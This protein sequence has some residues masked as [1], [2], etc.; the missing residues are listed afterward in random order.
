MW[1]F[2]RGLIIQLDMSEGS[3]MSETRI[4]RHRRSEKHVHR[5]QRCEIEG[6]EMNV[7]AMQQGRDGETIDKFSRSP[8]TA[9]TE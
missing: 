8:L 9:G 6:N 3:R 2:G 1:E 4:K 5:R 7:V